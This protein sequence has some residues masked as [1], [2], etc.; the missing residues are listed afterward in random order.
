MEKRA[1]VWVLFG[2]I[3]IGVFLAI[4]LGIYTYNNGGISDTNIINTQR[5]AKVEESENITDDALL[6]EVVETSLVD[7]KMSPSARI[8]EKRYYNKCDHLIREPKDIPIEL[9]NKSI[10][11]VESYYLGWSIEECTN[12]EVIIYKEFEGICDEHYIIKDNGGVLSIYLEDEHGVQRWKEDTQIDTQ[13]LPEKDIEEFK[14]GVRVV[15]KTNLYNFLED[16]E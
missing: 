11:E 8:I 15:G 2:I 14:V 6:N 13:Y 3:V 4:G 7:I 9:I 5:L 12:S 10:E 1:G 16:Y